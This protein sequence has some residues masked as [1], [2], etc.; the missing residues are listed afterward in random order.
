[1]CNLTTTNQDAAIEPLNEGLQWS[2]ANFCEN[3][4]IANF[5]EN[6]EIVPKSMFMAL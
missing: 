6:L 5:C 1:M 2:S 3:L 4:E